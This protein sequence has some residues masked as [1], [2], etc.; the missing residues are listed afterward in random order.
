MLSIM[1]TNVIS[2]PPPFLNYKSYLAILT[3]VQAHN[4]IKPIVKLHENLSV[5][6]TV[7]VRVELYETMRYPV[8]AENWIS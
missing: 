8:V 6:G 4:F 2:E 5:N 1:Y 7:I 3:A